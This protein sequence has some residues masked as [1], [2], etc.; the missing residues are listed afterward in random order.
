M[1][2]SYGTGVSD[3]NLA[4]F[5]AI[6][7]VYFFLISVSHSA[8]NAAAVRGKLRV[9][10]PGMNTLRL[11]IRARAAPVRR[12]RNL[13]ALS[14]TSQALPRARSIHSNFQRDPEPRSGS[15]SDETTQWR[16]PLRSCASPR[17]CGRTR[18]PTTT[19]TAT[20]RPAAARRPWRG[21]PARRW[22][23]E[24]ASLRATGR[25]IRAR[26][27]WTFPG[28]RRARRRPDAETTR[29]RRTVAGAA[30]ARWC[31]LTC[32]SRGGGRRG[33]RRSRCGR[34][35]AARASS[36]TCATTCCG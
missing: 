27:L 36:A 15:S 19:T 26:G 31:R 33:R 2:V 9:A 21:G 35:P 32:W 30:A 8:H 24:A 28:P 22:L 7:A 4:E 10:Q 16:A 1:V 3:S 23:R 13:F 17:C 6:F 11:Y 14:T 12:T 29:P 34:G 20:R 18:R 5:T 25:S